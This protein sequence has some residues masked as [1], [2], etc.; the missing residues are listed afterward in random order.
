MWKKIISAVMA[1]ALVVA[2]INYTP[3]TI[4][5]SQADAE[6]YNWSTV[7][8]LATSSDTTAYA[9]LYKMVLAEGTGNIDVIQNPG[10]TTA[11]GVYTTFS[12]ADFGEITLND[13]VTTAYSV[14][15]VGIV[16]HMDGFTE[17][18]NELTVKNS[19]GSV[20]ARFYV[21][22]E[23]GTGG[24]TSGSET[25]TETSEPTSGIL[26]PTG[27]AVYN[28]YP[29]NK[30]YQ[31]RF[32]AAEGAVS[33]N[34]YVDS[35]SEPVASVTASGEYVSADAFAAYADDGLHSVYLASVNEEGGVS[36]KSKAA[37]VRITTLTD[38]TS[39]PTDITRI[40]V[41]TNAGTKGGS[42]IT[43]ADKTAA[44]LTIISGEGDVKTVAD[45]GTIKR[46]GNSTS[47]A[48]KPAYN[49]SFSSK[50]KVFSNASKGKKWCLLANAYEKTLIRN[51]LA[52]DFGAQ[53]GNVCAPE[54]H[55]ADLYID[56]ILQGSYVISEPAENG[57]SEVQYDDK[58]TSDEI[59]FELEMERV[60]EECLYYRTS[61][62]GSRF[63]TEETLDTTSSRYQKWVS[64]LETFDR[65]LVN[66]SSDEVFNYIDVDSFVDMYIV[67][68]LFKTVDFGY[69]SVKFY[70]TYDAEGAPTIHAGPLWDFDLS[71][72]NS[73][74]AENRDSKRL[75]CLSENVWFN[76]LMRNNT[77]K[78]KVI[79]KFTK[80]QPIIQN[81]YKD[82]QLGTNQIT[83]HCNMMEQSRIRNYT[84]TSEGGAGWSESRAD[85]AEYSIYP[86]SYSTV[87]PYS[88]YTYDQ[89][90]EYLR[91]WLESRDKWLC[92]QW[93]I[94]YEEAGSA[95]MTSSDISVT[96]YQMT[97][98]FNGVDGTMGCRVVYQA[99]PTVDDQEVTE[100]GL[101]YGL[102][103]G[104]NPITEEDMV[105]GSDNE[106]V[107]AVPAT[108]AGKLDTV[109]GSSTTASYYAMTMESC[110]GVK[111]LTS[112][113]YVR[114]YAKLADGTVTYSDVKAYTVFKVADYIYQNR[115]T[116]KKST[117]DYLYSKVLSVVDR[118]YAT[119]DF[120]WSNTIVK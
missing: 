48:D 20:K 12:D 89:H 1:I 118:S 38:S 61:A 32:T 40:Y 101:V 22:Y 111:A 24:G 56:G 95:S 103:Y 67:N 16:F 55:Y 3:R 109:M 110:E 25:E 113:Y 63:V 112:K 76:Y 88:T 53:L 60:E 92:T 98:S 80:F 115:L 14:Q 104:E 15:G 120:D 21:Y 114:V 102:V 97:S 72:G 29:Q 31:I 11:P 119:V 99:E 41:V 84:A 30:G 28:F 6:S 43:K 85:S 66:T 27:V 108:T 117:F 49:I 26:A 4:D 46:R 94:D 79:D 106:Y 86:Y 17:K 73:S 91:T 52:M 74:F 35:N 7:N 70:I 13:T 36:A 69:S 75:G 50:Q 39:D 9:N 59:L 45:G 83:L 57:R 37:S 116:S 87:S 44:S 18:Y 58:D 2:T 100:I 96:G 19:A 93:G 42:T 23:N 81:L 62:T 78:T 82:N 8:Y 90:I 51:K 77:F 47:L 5:A 34:V 105:Y 64:T 10:F 65:A 33:Y 54:E 107:K 68:T 71:S